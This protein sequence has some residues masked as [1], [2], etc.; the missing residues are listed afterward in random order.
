MRSKKSMKEKGI[1]LIALIITIIVL[2]ILVGVTIGQIAGSDGIIKRAQNATAEYKQKSAEEKVTLLMHEYMIATAENPNQTLDNFLTK[3]NVEHT[4]NSDGTTDITVDGKTIKVNK[5]LSI[6]DGTNKGQTGSGNITY[7]DSDNKTQTLTKD[8][9][10]GTKIGTTENIDGQTLDWYLFDVSD[11]GKTAYLVSTP[12]YWVPDTDTKSIVNG[13]YTPKLVSDSDSSTAAMRQAIQSTKYSSSTGYDSNNVTYTPSDNTLNYYKSVNSKWRDKSAT[14]LTKDNFKTSLK[15][16]EQCA[17]YLA[18]A[19]IFAGIKSQVNDADGNLKEKIQTLVGGASIEQWCKAYNKQSAA[20]SS[21]I[22]CEY[23]ETN[24]PGYI[25]K[26][27][28]TAQNSGWYTNTD[29][30]F[31]NDIYGAVHK[32]GKT[33]ISPFEHSWWWL[34]S[35][36]SADSGNMCYVNSVIS[37]LYYG[38][39]YGYDYML[40]LF[41][42]VAL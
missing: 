23:Q 16:N 29:T 18:D 38:S 35:P 28:G 21:K 4:T 11:D 3:K 37:S 22:E 15:E 32:N 2:I 30:I 12:T 42:S 6:A 39:S 1:T 14:T 41:A 25:Y 24:A 9:A 40:S 8:T 5:D 7:T 10:A 31:G 13:A 34:A 36:S 17:C 33:S 20:S 26:V 27:N 19:E